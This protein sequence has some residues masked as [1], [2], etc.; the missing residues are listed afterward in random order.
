MKPLVC[1]KYFF[2]FSLCS[3]WMIGISIRFIIDGYM[4]NMVYMA[5]VF[6][7]FFD[8]GILLV[9]G[10]LLFVF[11]VFFGLKDSSRIGDT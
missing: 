4:N 3:A 9:F 10:V 5:N 2:F 8:W 11:S 7:L 1:S 6:D